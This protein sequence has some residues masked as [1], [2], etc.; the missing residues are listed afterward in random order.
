LVLGLLFALAVAG[1]RV[2]LGVHYPSDVL[3]AWAAAAAWVFGVAHFF[4]LRRKDSAGRPV[5]TD[6]V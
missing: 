2:W 6:P 5:R 1:S 3:A 4:R